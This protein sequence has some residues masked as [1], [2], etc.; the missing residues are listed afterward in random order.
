MD[1]LQLI[2]W[3]FPWARCVILAVLALF[4]GCG[5]G[6]RSIAIDGSSTVYPITEAVAEEFGKVQ[7]RIRVTVSISGTG[8]GFKRFCVGETVIS[9]AS[10]PIKPSESELAA[11]NDIGFI[12]LPVAYDGICVVVHPENSFVDHLSVEELKRIWQPNS[13]VHRWKDVRPEWPD[14]EIKLYGP[15]TASGTFDYFTEA[16]VGEG[17]A[18]R[19]DFVSNEDD[20]VLVQGVAGDPDALGYFG[21]AYFAQNTDKLKA[22]PVDGGEGPVTPSHETILEGSYQP[23]SR[24]VFIYV[25]QPAARER[26]EVAQFVAFYLD[27]AATL[28]PQVGYV[29]LDE[30]TY[31]LARDRFE[32][33]RTGSAFANQAAHPGRSIKELLRIANDGGAGGEQAI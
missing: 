8:G 23:L 30:E 5:E 4:A 13:A 15:G 33:R 31:A 17:G 20:N 29:P 3:R 6:R 25:S 21:Y 18:S 10:R 26:P 9:D 27:Q 24:P 19:A 2:V 14:R 22:V 16:I 32:K 12:E 1:S 7:P 28:V 11:K